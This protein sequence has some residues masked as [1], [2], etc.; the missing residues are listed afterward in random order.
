MIVMESSWPASIA[1][2]DIYLCYI[3]KTPEIKAVAEEVWKD[4]LKDGYEVLFDDRQ[5]GPGQMFKD[6][7]LIGLPVRILIGEKDF[8]ATGEIEVKM[9]KSGE[10]LKV[11]KDE[12][13]NTV[14]KKLSELGKWA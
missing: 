7:D 13:L 12:L 10:S 14:K 3:G 1:P 11:K 5:L 6:S 9:R 2:Y 4:L 8:N